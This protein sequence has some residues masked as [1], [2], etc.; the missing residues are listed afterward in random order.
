MGKNKVRSYK[1][2]VIKTD[3]PLEEKIKRV[4]EADEESKKLT[5]WPKI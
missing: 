4:E 5:E 3:L 2:V 1:D